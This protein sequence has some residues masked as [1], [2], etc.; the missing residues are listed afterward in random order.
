[1]TNEPA[2]FFYGLGAIFAACREMSFE[3][4]TLFGIERT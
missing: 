4:G 3:R 1:L 2:G